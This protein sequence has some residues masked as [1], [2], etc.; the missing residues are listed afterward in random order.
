MALPAVSFRS[1]FSGLSEVE[2]C[3]VRSAC[4]S[5]LDK[6]RHLRLNPVSGVTRFQPGSRVMT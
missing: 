6:N 2:G 5:P 1:A 4:R 3:T